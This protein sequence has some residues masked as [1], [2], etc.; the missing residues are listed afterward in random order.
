[1]VVLPDTDTDAG[2][3][4]GGGGGVVPSAASCTAEGASPA[5]LAGRTVT[6]TA[7]GGGG[8]G[9][10]GSHSKGKAAAAAAAATTDD[11]AGGESSTGKIAARGGRGQEQGLESKSAAPTPA[12]SVRPPV[13]RATYKRAAAPGGPRDP[14]GCWPYKSSRTSLR[15]T[16]KMRE[17]MD[18]YCRPD[19]NGGGSIDPAWREQKQAEDRQLNASAPR[20]PLQ[21][22]FGAG[23]GAA[24]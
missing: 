4:G 17:Q 20:P 13:S 19:G 14:T 21:R 12:G 23:A 11:K 8:G 2:G 16:E 22:K 6:S 1:M 7:C 10:G 5:N 3:G 15:E 24:S 9:S 18:V